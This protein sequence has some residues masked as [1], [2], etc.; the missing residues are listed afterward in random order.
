MKIEEIPQA[1]LERLPLY[2][3]TLQ[4]LEEKGFKTVSSQQ[5]AGFLNIKAEKLRKDLALC[6]T[7]GIKSIGYYVTA[8]R[9][10]IENFLGLNYR[11]KIGIVGASNLG[12]ALATDETFT[13]LGFEISAIFDKDEN[14]IG[15]EIGDVKIYDFAKIESISQRKMIDI[16]V[17]AVQKEF[18]QE[19]AD[20]LVAAKVLGIWNFAPVKIFVPNDV[21]VLDADLSFGLSILNYEVTQAEKSRR[22]KV[23]RKSSEK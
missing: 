6:G 16:G 3:R 5:L 12:F 7:F 9:K 4:Q 11:R 13:Q 18:A 10:N 19:A 21:Q 14:F 8:L 17:I 1:T 15:Q 23:T 22:K 20:A 2:H